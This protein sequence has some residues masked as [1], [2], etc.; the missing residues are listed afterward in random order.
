MISPIA[1]ATAPVAAFA[2]AFGGA[3]ASGIV[4]PDDWFTYENE[5]FDVRAS[6]PADFLVGGDARNGDGREFYSPDGDAG[7]AVGVVPRHEPMRERR[8]SETLMLQRQGAEIAE[9]TT[10][11]GWFLHRGVWDEEVFYRLTKAGE[12]CDGEPIF[13]NLDIRYET[14]AREPYGVLIEPIA[15]SLSAC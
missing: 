8:L 6:I 14:D 1:Y 2:A 12:T 10:G 3:I 11:D 15:D 4:Q 9:V 7:V 13:V 5:R